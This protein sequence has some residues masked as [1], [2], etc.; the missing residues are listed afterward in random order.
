MK[1][2]LVEHE[3]ELGAVVESLAAVL[4]EVS[5][6]LAVSEIRGMLL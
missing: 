3:R 2:R 1:Q 4:G 5:E 6:L